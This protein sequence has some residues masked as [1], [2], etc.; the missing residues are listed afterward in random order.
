MAQVT[1]TD[2]NR[3][4]SGEPIEIEVPYP[5]NDRGEDAKWFMA[6]PS[7]WLYDMALAVGEA[8]EAEAM[9]Q[10]EMERAKTLPP[11]K[12]WIQ[13]QERSR[14]SAE[15]RIAELEAKAKAKTIVPEEEIELDIQ[16][17]Y[18]ERLIK[19][20]EYSRAEEI[21]SQVAANARNNYFMQRLVI[22]EAGKLLFDPATKEGRE[23][24]ERIGRSNKTKLLT[25]LTQAVL[26]VQIA[27]NYSAG[28]SSD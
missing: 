6:Q 19:P 1:T 10:P 22:D 24:W 27:K 4:V 14:K 16:R 17:S 21:S 18:V 28:P 12:S 3:V 11:S 25:P 7:D 26:L 2:I 15:D 23:R 5:L 20:D 9:Q 8:A 13:R